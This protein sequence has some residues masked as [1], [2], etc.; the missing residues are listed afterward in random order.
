M[1]STP[2]G[3]NWDVVIESLQYPDNPSHEAWMPNFN[4]AEDV[5]QNFVS[6]YWGTPGLDMDAELDQLVEDL[7][8][9]FDEAE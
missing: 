6:N 9:V 7:Q 3:V 4:Q 2:Q 1:R 5:L 8:A